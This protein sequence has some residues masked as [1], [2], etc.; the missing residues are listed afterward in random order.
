MTMKNVFLI[1]LMY[2][3]VCIK[4]FVH[5]IMMCCC[6]YQ[7]INSQ[8]GALI[9]SVC[10]K[11][12]TTLKPWSFATTRPVKPIPF[13]Y[14]ELSLMRDDDAVKKCVYFKSIS[15][16]IGRWSSLQNI[17]MYFFIPKFWPCFTL[18]FKTCFLLCSFFIC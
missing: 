13:T 14:H 18:A 9:L 3:I 2:V 16:S 10:V 15:T 1:L 6:I 11:V 8:T 4:M 12:M 5:V 7:V 17:E